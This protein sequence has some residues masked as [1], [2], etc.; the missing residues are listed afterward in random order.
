MV[1]AC[2]ERCWNIVDDTAKDVA[3]KLGY[4]STSIVEVKTVSAMDEELILEV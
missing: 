2:K 4:L 1:R 3:M